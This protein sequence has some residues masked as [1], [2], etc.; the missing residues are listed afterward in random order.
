MQAMLAVK[1]KQRNMELGGKTPK[2]AQR[3]RMWASRFDD[4][5]E[6]TLSLENGQVLRVGHW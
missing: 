4:F 5:F 2:I 3:R 1:E 6:D